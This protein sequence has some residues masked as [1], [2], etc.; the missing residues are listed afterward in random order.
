M[1]F[2]I[3][4]I[5]SGIEVGIPVHL[6]TLI[7]NNVNQ[8]SILNSNLNN[9]IFFVDPSAYKYDKFRLKIIFDLNLSLKN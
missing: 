5:I 7:S 1:K 6:L 8:Y 9:Q 2:N 3:K 4:P